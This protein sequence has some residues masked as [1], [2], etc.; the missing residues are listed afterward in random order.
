MQ[1][2]NEQAQ[3]QATVTKEDAETVRKRSDI[4]RNTPA[5][6]DPVVYWHHVVMDAV[7]SSERDQARTRAAVEGRDRAEKDLDRYTTRLTNE[8]ARQRAN[9]PLDLTNLIR[10]AR[11]GEI[12]LNL[13]ISISGGAEQDERKG[14]CCE[15]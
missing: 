8:I 9:A 5:G 1:E 12:N 10:M 14:C 6:Y 7:H 11:D 15:D 3:E 4:I 2:Y 13:N